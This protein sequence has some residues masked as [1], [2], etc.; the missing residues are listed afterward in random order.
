MSGRA[1]AASSTATGARRHSERLSFVLGVSCAAARGAAAGPTAAP[2]DEFEVTFESGAPLELLG[3]ADGA[4]RKLA[5]ES[6][7]LPGLVQAA[8]EA[9]GGK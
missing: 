5:E 7:D 8:Q 6:G 1:F 4:F 3:R 9:A 2:V